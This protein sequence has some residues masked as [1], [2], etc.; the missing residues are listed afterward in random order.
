MK[1]KYLILIL[2]AGF[3]LSFKEFAGIVDDINNGLKAGNA[4]AI[5]RYFNASVDL[6]LP[7]NEGMYSKA[8]AEQILKDFFSKNSVKSFSVLHQGESKDGAQYIMGSL[9]TSNGTFRTYCYLK[10]NGDGFMI[11]ELRIES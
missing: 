7:G 10:K 1:T 2:L 6:N 3:S 11:K 8:Q 4:A 9:V 5:A